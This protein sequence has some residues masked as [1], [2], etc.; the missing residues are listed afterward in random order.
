[1]TS[2]RVNRLALLG[3]LS[4]QYLQDVTPVVADWTQRAE[5]LSTWVGRH[6]TPETQP[7]IVR[8]SP[9]KPVDSQ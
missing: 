4:E 3:A 2:T 7:I 9:L 8:V 1:M 6:A 5:A